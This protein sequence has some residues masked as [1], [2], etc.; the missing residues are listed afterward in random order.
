MDA[1]IL[2]LMVLSTEPEYSLPLWI[3][4]QVTLLSWRTRVWAHVMCSMFHTYAY[5]M[6]RDTTGQKGQHEKGKLWDS[7]WVSCHNRHWKD[8]SLLTVPLWLAGSRWCP[9][10]PSAQQ[11]AP[12]SSHPT[13]NACWSPFNEDKQTAIH[14]LKFHTPDIHLSPLKQWLSSDWKAPWN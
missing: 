9:H 1:P 4:K 13:P 11:L 5:H 14:D 6:N 12:W 3:A 7:L 2:T 10:A 8:V